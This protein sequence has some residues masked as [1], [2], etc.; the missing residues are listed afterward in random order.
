MWCGIF[1][2][3]QVCSHDDLGFL[4]WYSRPKHLDA[5]SSIGWFWVSP[6]VSTTR[7]SHA[8]AN[9]NG[10]FEQTTTSPDNVYIQDSQLFIKPTL[11]DESLINTNNVINLLA[12]GS[13]TSTS[14]SDCVATTNIT[15]GTIVNPVKSARLN[16]LKGAS[17]KYGRI[18]VVAQMPKVS[19]PVQTPTSRSLS[20]LLIHDFPGR[21]DLARNLDASRQQ[22]L[23]LLAPL[24]RNRPRRV[25]RQQQHLPPRRQQCRHV[26]ST[27][28][29]RQARRS[30]SADHRVKL[31][32]AHHLRFV[33]L[34]HVISSSPAILT[35]HS[36]RLPHLRPRMVRTLPLHLHRLPPEPVS[37]THLTLPTKRIV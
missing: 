7:T 4:V 13:C 8:N 23:R 32:L 5:R 21:L 12:D 24:R 37:Y 20:P 15:N 3:W 22:H 11:Q 6:Y 19:H 25:P 14:W 17:I 1:S 18:E 16:T 28:G 2:T 36:K 10:E 35:L 33:F 27:L 30:V 26:Y 31:R 29:P 9:S 34:A